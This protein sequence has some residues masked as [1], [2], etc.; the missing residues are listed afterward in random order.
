MDD[1]DQQYCVED[2][3]IKTE[4]IITDPTLL[5]YHN[6]MTQSKCSID[7]IL[8]S[9]TEIATFNQNKLKILKNITKQ[10]ENFNNI[11][12]NL[13]NNISYCKSQVLEHNKIK[14]DK[15]FGT[16]NL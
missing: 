1:S 12:I 7:G 6:L 5:Y 4:E 11:K 8:N 9:I 3:V 10:I 2:F 13:L 15:R 14:K 16:S